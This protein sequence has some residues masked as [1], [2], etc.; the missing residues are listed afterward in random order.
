M[1]GQIP[2]WEIHSGPYKGN[3]FRCLG[4]I[5]EE[6]SNLACPSAMQHG[7]GDGGS[8]L[9]LLER[10]SESARSAI[11]AHLGYQQHLHPLGRRL[12]SNYQYDLCQRYYLGIQYTRIMVTVYETPP[13]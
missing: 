7:M 1:E 12:H 8:V 11:P 3:I 10:G 2:D 9:Q 6:H 5:L 4:F 13:G